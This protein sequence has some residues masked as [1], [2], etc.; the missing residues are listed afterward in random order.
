MAGGRGLWVSALKFLKGWHRRECR[1][2]FL[3]KEIKSFSKIR[4]SRSQNYKG[5]IF[6]GSTPGPSKLPA[7]WHLGWHL[8]WH[9]LYPAMNDTMPGSAKIQTP[10]LLVSKLPWG[11]LLRQFWKIF[12]N[13]HF[14]DGISLA[15]EGPKLFWEKLKRQTLG[16]IF[17]EKKSRSW[18]FLWKKNDD[19]WQSNHE[20]YFWNE[21]YFWTFLP[22]SVRVKQ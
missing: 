18:H 22:P 3:K 1:Y 5:S 6:F 9:F 8:G 13:F 7:K 11:F 15:M 21:M 19:T 17:L 16:R 2:N 14:M 20:M 4:R 12:H 10:S